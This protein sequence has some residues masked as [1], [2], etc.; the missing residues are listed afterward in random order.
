VQEAIADYR[1]SL[2]ELK[3]DL[4]DKSNGRLSEYWKAVKVAM[5]V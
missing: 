3:Q 2:R 1:E 5:D 4:G